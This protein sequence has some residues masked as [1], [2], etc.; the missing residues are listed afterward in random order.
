MKQPKS[1]VYTF[2]WISF[3]ISLGV[4]LLVSSFALTLGAASI[5]FQS[6]AEIFLAH[7]FGLQIE[8]PIPTSW[9][10][11]VWDIRLPRIFLAATVGASLAV[12]GSTYQGLFR[13]HLADPYLIGVAS[14]AGFGA[15]LSLLVFGSALTVG[16]FTTVP[17]TAF[18]F[19]L[20][21]VGVAYA[22]AKKH[23]GTQ[24]NTL[25]LAGVALGSL[26][27]SLTTFLLMTSGKDIRPI[28]SFLFGSFAT[29]NW[30]DVF[31]VLPYLSLG[32]L[33]TL[34]L[35]RV[36][37]ILQLNQEQATQLGVDTEKIRLYLLIC[38]S[39]VTASAVSV[40]G[41]I[42]FIGLIT[43]HCVRL[44]WGYDYRT[45]LP[46]SIVV[47]AIFLIISDSIA[48]TVLSPQ[49]IPVGVVTALFGS[50]FFLYILRK[51]HQIW[52]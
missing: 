47:G 3:L 19:A 51:R 46:F 10:T 48:R 36:L 20:L 35:S 13:N 40:S 17:I 16:M 30:H 37:N 38:S 8:L 7:V 49:E 6:S 50:P 1:T 12:A 2:P 27:S 21:T 29:A 24:T 23:G 15:T 31:V 42:G 45:L 14:G 33:I 41:V 4:M 32:T 52:Y 25:I 22:L 5:P 28:L 26:M 18:L 34:P 43:P 9:D 39:L 44:V 11:I